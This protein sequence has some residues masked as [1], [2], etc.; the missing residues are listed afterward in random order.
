[1]QMKRTL[2]LVMACFGAFT[3]IYAGNS[4]KM[5]A[6]NSIKFSVTK[7]KISLYNYPEWNI[8]KNYRLHI[9]RYW[10]GNTENVANKLQL[11]GVNEEI[12]NQKYPYFR[13][14][15][16]TFPDNLQKA[17]LLYFG[18]ANEGV[19]E[20]YSNI[21]ETP[22][23]KE[24]IKKFLQAGGV[25]F[26]DYCS[27]NY[28]D[29]R[30]FKKFIKDGGT[31][32]PGKYLPESYV[33][34]ANP[35]ESGSPLLN[36][37]NGKVRCFGGWDK[38]KLPKG[39]AVILQ[40]EK[41]NKAAVLIQKVYGKGTIIYSQ[42]VRLFRSDCKNYPAV[43]KLEKNI[44]DF[45][46]KN[47]E[48][49]KTDTMISDGPK[50]VVKKNSEAPLIDGK[51]NDN[52]WRN[53]GFS[54]KIYNFK[55]KKLYNS[56]MKVAAL[57][58][59]KWLFFAFKINNP[60]TKL[61]SQHVLKNGGPVH[62]DES[63]EIFIDPGTSGKRYYHYLLNFGNV[64][65]QQMGL[66]GG[67]DRDKSWK[68][69]W[70]SAINK[71]N[72]GWTAEVALPL[73]IFQKYCD[74]A[75]AKINI[76]YNNIQVELDQYGAKEKQKRIVYTWSPKLI[77]GAHEINNFGTLIGIP[78]KN[79]GK[80]FLP[81]V[82][83]IKTQG[84]EIKGKQKFYT[85]EVRLRN[86]ADIDG[87]TKLKILDSCSDGSIKTVTKDLRLSGRQQKTVEIDVPV[88]NL[89]QR[90]YTV[91]LE[92]MAGNTRFEEIIDK[93]AELNMMSKLTQDRNYYTVEKEIKIRCNLGFPETEM[94]NLKLLIKNKSGK[95]LNSTKSPGKKV[96][97]S[98]PVEQFLPGN[99]DIYVQLVNSQNHIL[100]SGH[101]VVNKLNPN[102]GHEVKI[103]L[104]RKIVL[105]DN[106][107]FYPFGIYMRLMGSEQKQIFKM[108]SEGGFNTIGRVFTYYDRYKNEYI[109][110]KEDGKAYMD[111]ALK[112][113]LAVI[114]WGL[115]FEPKACSTP[116]KIN[117]FYNFIMPRITESID[118]MKQ[119]PNYL[120][121]KNIDEPNLASNGKQRVYASG[122]F[123]SIIRKLD[124]YH[125]LYTLFARDIPEKYKSKWADI[126]SS[127]I[128]NKPGWKSIYGKIAEHIAKYTI[129][130]KKEADKKNK[131]LWIVPLSSQLDPVRT[132]IPLSP[133]QQRCQTYVAAI[134][135]AKGIIYFSWGITYPRQM[136]NAICDLAKEFKILSPALLNY[137]VE[138][139]IK[140]SPGALIPEKERFPMVHAALFRYSENK[141]LLLAANGKTFPVKTEFI[142]PELSAVSKIGRLF[143]NKQNCRLKSGAFIDTLEPYGTRAYL[144]EAGKVLHEPV[145]F[146]L[147]MHPDNSKAIKEVDNSANLKKIKKQK[148]I[149][150]NPSFER[151]SVYPTFPDNVSCTA[152][153]PNVG[154]SDSGFYL[155]SANPW[156]GKYSLKLNRM[157]IGGCGY[158][159][160]RTYSCQEAFLT[161][162]LPDFTTAKKY[163]FS[164]YAKAAK[165]G[166]ELKIIVFKFNNKAKIFKLT[167]NWKRYS[168]SD[169]IKDSRTP[170]LPGSTIM[171]VPGND[172]TIWLDALQM[173]EGT[174]PSKYTENY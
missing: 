73:S 97:V 114:A 154:E 30:S 83:Q 3:Y 66:A 15:D 2:I 10:I 93:P 157:D 150:A 32:F 142:I 25:L 79:T 168:F 39:T 167:T 71:D 67:A 51:L 101:L 100:C 149:I 43:D 8:D 134:Y 13:L 82:E 81:E 111:E 132:P 18:K 86:Y 131:V 37:L 130:M 143:G 156:D 112:N 129:K 117:K 116:D 28:L 91:L 104:F 11:C 36:G 41:N 108:L 80:A 63:I 118:M 38:A 26:L 119:Y 70:I 48:K 4:K 42:V 62:L 75:R 144:I 103:D 160:G 173:E 20:E 136:W 47:T 50:L 22:D 128:Y 138:Q 31:E 162:Y 84:Y 163:T 61:I 169:E 102:P 46:F 126:W 172:S 85:V 147:V 87:N 74:P 148:N 55:N 94:R 106:K 34:T 64:K 171:L 99:T 124:Q 107:P 109:L 77:H 19:L 1:M 12:W 146:S 59:N 27:T 6:V 78:Q 152:S 165:D 45:V 105:K 29:T 166:Q 122:V 151:C 56:K 90:N 88:N 155:D 121:T 57:T 65:A 127:D 141:Y 133:A 69:P 125:P 95:I 137:E 96:S 76:I 140:Y 58:D 158:L 164:F 44:I 161:Y 52:V 170:W 54:S 92:D 5:V 17:K 40:G 113:N 33:A 98:V 35:L 110:G 21:F 159:T 120:C 174:A 115:Q 49:L 153:L 9:E 72:K 60:N 7:K 139:N 16:K 123:S 53:A 24:A 68:L 145:E 14:I 23:Y 135:G 89:V